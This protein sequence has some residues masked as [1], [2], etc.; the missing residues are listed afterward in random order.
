[1]GEGQGDDVPSAM[2]YLNPVPPY[3]TTRE[4]CSQPSFIPHK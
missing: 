4:S 2:Y 3:N 1:M